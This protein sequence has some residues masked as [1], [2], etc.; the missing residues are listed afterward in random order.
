MMQATPTV[1]WDEAGHTH[2]GGGVSHLDSTV[3]LHLPQQH[4]ML[5]SGR[6]GEFSIELTL[7]TH[8]QLTTLSTLY[9]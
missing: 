5:C 7:H 4:L 9:I 1:V 8:L 2:N 6:E 3:S